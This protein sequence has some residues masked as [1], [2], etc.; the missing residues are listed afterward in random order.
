MPSVFG[1]HNLK[2]N[3]ET[4]VHIVSG[5]N[6]EFY[7][8]IVN[9]IEENLQGEVNGERAVIVIFENEKILKELFNDPVYLCYQ[10][11]TDY[12]TEAANVEEVDAGV[13]RATKMGNVT[14]LTRNYGR[15]TDFIILDDRVKTNGGI[16][17]IQT[18]IPE[19]ESELIQIKGRSAR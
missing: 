5:S 15:G 19:S 7:K 4:D 11:R 2:F 6:S 3:E 16:C 18:F 1:K 8:K 17:T 13:L 14:F 9:V 10:S 12:L